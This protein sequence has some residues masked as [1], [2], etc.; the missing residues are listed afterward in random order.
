MKHSSGS[1]DAVFD[2]TRDW[3]VY[4]C[5]HGCL[6]VAIDR[7]MVTLT[8]DEFHALQD[9]LRRAC[10]RFHTRASHALSAVRAH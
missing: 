8:D 10:D 7:L 2:P 4:R 9:L 1:A 5:D 6:H 3:A